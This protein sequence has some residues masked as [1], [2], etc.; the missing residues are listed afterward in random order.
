MNY[1]LMGKVIECQ[2]PISKVK[3]PKICLSLGR[4]HRTRL[5][6]GRVKNGLQNSFLEIPRIKFL[7]IHREGFFRIEAQ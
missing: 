6:F 7:Q 4:V 5:W 3:C 2:S 1:E